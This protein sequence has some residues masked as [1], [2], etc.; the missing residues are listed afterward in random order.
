MRYADHGADAER[1]AKLALRSETGTTIDFARSLKIRLPGRP[2]NNSTMESCLLGIVLARAT[3]KSL[4]ELTEAKL[5]D[6]LHLEYPATWRVES[7]SRFALTGGGLSMSARVLA[8]IGQLML[9]EGRAGPTQILPQSWL[10]RIEDGRA[11]AYD[12]KER[13][14]HHRELWW[15]EPDG[16][17]IVGRGY[18]GQLLYI[19]RPSRTVV[20]KLS[21]VPDAVPFYP[22]EDEMVSALAAIVRSPAH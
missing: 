15:I 18:M 11:D 3:G 10:A 7:R 8:R 2:Y 1:W 6:P 20:V 19:D 4:A 16:G 9:D 17:A 12:A 21:Y 22:I 5:W 14:W 13:G